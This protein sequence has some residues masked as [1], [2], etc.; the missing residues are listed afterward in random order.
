[1]DLP[2]KSV[3]EVATDWFSLP[4]GYIRS[5]SDDVFAY[6][7]SAP[8]N[9]LTTVTTI[10]EDLAIKSTLWSTIC[11]LLGESIP[12]AAV[13]MIVYTDSITG[14]IIPHKQWS[15]L[16]H[17]PLESF[18]SK[19]FMW[20]YTPNI[21]LI[22]HKIIAFVQKF[23]IRICGNDLSNLNSGSNYLSFV[24]KTITY[25]FT[26]KGSDTWIL[27]ETVRSTFHKEHLY[28]TGV[29]CLLQDFY[30]SHVVVDKIDCSAIANTHI[31]AIAHVEMQELIKTTDWIITHTEKIIKIQI[32]DKS[33]SIPNSMANKINLQFKPRG[34]EWSVY[35]D[36]R[37]TIKINLHHSQIWTDDH[38]SV[39]YLKLALDTVEKTIAYITL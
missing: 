32:P 2:V 11:P 16:L 22:P 24:Y 27:V 15:I 37:P 39:Y 20:K 28:S 34:G 9:L 8:A 12:S 26:Y 25:D 31:Q 17:I 38:I 4:R 23:I 7:Q 35:S 13:T 1:M 14:F 3:S 5:F 19:S 36:T 30:R 21:E 6:F 33:N 29:F 18:K 10:K